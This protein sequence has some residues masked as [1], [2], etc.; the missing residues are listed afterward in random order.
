MMATFTTNDYQ[1]ILI[2]A[3]AVR[4]ARLAGVGADWERKRQRL[5][6][7]LANTA[8]DAAARKAGVDDA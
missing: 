6:A 8:R 4:G 2:L 5:A 7:L 3:N 1:E